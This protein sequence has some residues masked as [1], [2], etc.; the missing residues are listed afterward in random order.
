MDFDLDTGTITGL[1]GVST[2]GDQLTVV[3]NGTVGAGSLIVPIGT[4]AQRPTFP[5]NGA[6][7]YNTTLNKTEYWDG[8]VWRSDVTSLAKSDDV[9]LVSP[10]VGNILQ[11]DGSKW[12]NSL[13]STPASAAGTLNSWTLLSGTKYY[14]D[15]PHNLGTNNIVITLYN[16]V[17][18]AIVYAD[19]IVLTTT[20]I[21]RVTVTGNTSNLRIVVIANGMYVGGAGTGIM[22]D[23]LANRP[24]AGTINRIFLAY[25]TKVLYRDNGISWDIMA[26]SSGVVKSLSYFATSLDSPTTADF[27]INSLAPAVS[28]PANTSLSVRQFSNTIEQGVAMTVPVPVGAANITFK[29]RGRATTAPVAAANVQ[30]KIYIRQIP[31]NAAIGTW[32]AG[33][34]FTNYPVPLNNFYQLYSQTFTLTSLGMAVDNTYQIELTRPIAGVTNNLAS[35]WLLAELTVVFN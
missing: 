18:N 17:T 10:V 24:P 31:N 34:S 9:N 29:I 14:A 1:S 7:R 35:A 12:T 13:A 33:S 19:S 6:W 15:F 16:A 32:S 21:L 8:T 20:N 4:T 22:T 5:I 25:D 11:Y 30:H 28:D 3:T 27:A 2:P 23:I 26:A